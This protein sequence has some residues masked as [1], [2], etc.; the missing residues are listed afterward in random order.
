MIKIFIQ[1]FTFQYGATKTVLN[2]NDFAV[3]E[4]FTFQ[5]GATKT[6]LFKTLYITIVYI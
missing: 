5:Y 3:D 1:I 2:D 6:H 4:L